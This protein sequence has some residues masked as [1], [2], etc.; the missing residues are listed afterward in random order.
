MCRGGGASSTTPASRRA[1]LEWSYKGQGTLED[2]Y[3]VDFLPD[4]TRNP[5]LFPAWYKWSITVF[6][7]IAVLAVAFVST[8]YSSAVGEIVDEFHI[9][10]PELAISGISLFVLGFAVGPVFWAP[11][12]EMY[13]RQITFFISYAA[14]TALNA[15][16][17]ASKNIGTIAVLR[18]LAGAF[19]SSPLTNS[20]GV[21]ADMFDAKDRGF[22]GAL[23]AMAPACSPCARRGRSGSRSSAL[24]SRCPCNNRKV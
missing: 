1:V 10:S 16:T 22:A 20:G 7:A 15:G 17:C 6:K 3:V 11:L 8:A 18:F 4:D 14:L 19:G 9:T 5:F 12:G 13:G 2:P 24:A 21:I 23:F